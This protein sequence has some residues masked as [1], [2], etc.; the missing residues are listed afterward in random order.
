MYCA[1]G[2]LHEVRMEG[3]PL[4]PNNNPQHQY[5]PHPTKPDR[6]K[7]PKLTHLQR[8]WT[9]GTLPQGTW[10]VNEA[11][12]VHKSFTATSGNGCVLIALWSGSHADIIDAEAP[13][14]PNIQQAVD[15]MDQKLAATT[16]ACHDDWTRIKETFLPASERLG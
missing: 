2:A 4:L 13:V 8:R 10:L 5:D 6:L 9:F 7:G 12:S 3:P 11:G 15:I 14:Q 1:R 16:C